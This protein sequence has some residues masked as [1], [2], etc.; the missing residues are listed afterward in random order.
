MTTYRLDHTSSQHRLA[1]TTIRHDYI[2]QRRSLARPHTAHPCTEQSNLNYSQQAPHGHRATAITSSE[3]L[4]L[5]LTSLPP[6]PPLLHNTTNVLQ[7]LATT[8]S[9]STT[10]T[11]HSS[12]LHQHLHYYRN[13]ATVKT[14]QTRRA[15]RPRRY[16][17]APLARMLDR[18]T[19]PP[20]A[21]PWRP[22][23]TFSQH[24]CPTCPA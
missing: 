21:T 22:P 17:N 10:T 14:P 6:P 1:T 20:L 11:I 5:R 7:P 4:P 23:P 19:P 16:N 18:Y 2:P 12:C 13:Q 15:Y 24:I 9:S 3:T 8:I